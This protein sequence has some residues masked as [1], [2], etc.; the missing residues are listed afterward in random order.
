MFFKKKEQ[1]ALHLKTDS[2]VVLSNV[3]FPTDYNLLWDSARKSL[4]V[5]SKISKTYELK[6]WR[7]INSKIRQMKLCQSFKLWQSFN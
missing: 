2:F 5:I 6:A 4:R 3:H 1:E 7:K